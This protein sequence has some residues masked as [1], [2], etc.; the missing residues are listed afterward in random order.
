MD[1]VRLGELRA[2]A[3]EFRLA[4]ERSLAE[5]ASPA[6]PYFPDGACRLVS[7]LLALHLMQRAPWSE[8]G[9]RFVSAHL[10]GQESYVRH[11]WLAVDDSVVDLTADAFGQHPVIVGDPIAFHS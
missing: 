6:L 11:T 1:A 5:R 9:L 3:S 10:P 7:R 2:A 4:I 8:A